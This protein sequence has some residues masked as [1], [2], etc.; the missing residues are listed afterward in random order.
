[1]GKMH[2]KSEEVFTTLLLL[3]ATPSFFV[4]SPSLSLRHSMADDDGEGGE[5][6][7]VEEQDDAGAAARGGSALCMNPVK[8]AL[9]VGRGA[10]TW[11]AHVASGAHAEHAPRALRAVLTGVVTEGRVAVLVLKKHGLVDPKHRVLGRPVAS[12]TLVRDDDSVALCCGAAGVWPQLLIAQMRDALIS[13]DQTKPIVVTERVLTCKEPGKAT[14]WADGLALKKA[15]VALNGLLPPGGHAAGASQDAI[16]TSFALCSAKWHEPAGLS[17]HELVVHECVAPASAAPSDMSALVALSRMRSWWLSDWLLRDAMPGTP[18]E[19]CLFI[20]SDSGGIDRYAEWL[21]TGMK[22]VAHATRAEI[23]LGRPVGRGSTPE[24]ERG[25][26]DK[27]SSRS[28]SGTQ[29]SS[30]GSGSPAEELGDA[31]GQGATGQ[32]AAVTRKRVAQADTPT[33]TEK[34]D[35]RVPG[36]SPRA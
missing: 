32:G 34:A 30:A 29:G 24:W 31:A 3:P 15:V 4:L 12:G 33:T 9:P 6:W 25:C 17:G 20:I 21:K 28:R 10:E 23:L 16:G 19:D 2:C 5:E 14:G 11:S 8:Q 18:R 1:M 27:S 22:A 35:R 7:E 26:N 36:A 13:R